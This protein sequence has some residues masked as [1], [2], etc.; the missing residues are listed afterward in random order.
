M[1]K[2]ICIHSGLVESSI[3]EQNTNCIIEKREKFNCKIHTHGTGEGRKKHNQD[4]FFYYELH[5]DINHHILG[6]ARMTGDQRNK[7]I[8]RVQ[9]K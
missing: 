4:F 5:I 1:C 8:F 2:V 7:C 3:C 6:W 9:Q